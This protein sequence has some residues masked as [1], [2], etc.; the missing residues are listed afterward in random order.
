M[1]QLSNRHL[2]LFGLSD[3]RSFFGSAERAII[4]DAGKRSVAEGVVE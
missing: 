2:F 4:L 1:R 3:K